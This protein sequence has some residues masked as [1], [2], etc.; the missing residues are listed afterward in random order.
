MRNIVS[1]VCGFPARFRDSFLLVGLV[2]MLTGCAD[3]KSFA[4]RVQDASTGEPV[5]YVTI[6]WTQSW[7]K[8]GASKPN[9][10]RSGFLFSGETN[11]IRVEGLLDSVDNTFRLSATGYQPLTVDYIPKS[12]PP[13]VG[14]FNTTLSPRPLQVFQSSS[15]T[16]KIQLRKE[17]SSAARH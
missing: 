9:R 14:L 6:Y 1:K 15:N 17:E 8:M 13:A 10:T 4:F 16:I 5:N 7:Q 3:L 11:V 12:E 2:V